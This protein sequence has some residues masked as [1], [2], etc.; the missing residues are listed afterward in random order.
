[1]TKAAQVRDSDTVVEFV[2]YEDLGFAEQ[3][4]GDDLFEADTAG[5]GYRAVM[6][7]GPGLYG[8]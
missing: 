6:M 4:G 1:M 3:F 2:G 5:V 8:G 7:E